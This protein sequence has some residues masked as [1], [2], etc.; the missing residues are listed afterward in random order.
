[1]ETQT[2]ARDRW[3][4]GETIGTSAWRLV[5][6][7]EIDAFGTLTDD[8]EPLH[9]DPAWCA[10]HSPVGRPIL[11][12]F[13]TLALLTALL[14]DATAGALFAQ[15]GAAEYPLNYGFDRIRFVSPV[16][17]D[18]RIRA[19]FVLA[20]RTQ[21]R[22]GMLMRIDVSVEIEGQTRPA[23]TAVWLTLWVSPRTA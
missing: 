5:T 15:P 4:I 6:Q 23:L 21:R 20:E 19:N 2:P 8:V 10:E 17:V 7:A 11:Y 13:Q 12:G 9:M 16:P 1:M 22:D 18:T 3:Q 14:R